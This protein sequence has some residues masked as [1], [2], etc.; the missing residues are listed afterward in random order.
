MRD[1]QGPKRKPS[2][3][4]EVEAHLESHVHGKH[5]CVVWEGAEGKGLEMVPR[6]RPTSRYKVPENAVRVSRLLAWC[7]NFLTTED[8]ATL[9]GLLQ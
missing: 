8:G 4:R 9:P 2:S 3:H 7:G 1:A 6:Q 5:A